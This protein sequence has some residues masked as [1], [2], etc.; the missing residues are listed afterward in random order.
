[1]L[2]YLLIVL[3]KYIDVNK[4]LRHTWESSHFVIVTNILNLDIKYNLLNYACANEKI[5]I[6]LKDFNYGP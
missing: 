4:A 1:M 3:G 5:D 2:K 6:S